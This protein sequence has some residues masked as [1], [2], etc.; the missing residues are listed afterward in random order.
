MEVCYF[1][2]LVPRHDAKP[3]LLSLCLCDET[4]L[5]FPFPFFFSSLCVSICSLIFLL[6]FLLLDVQARRM[7]EQERLD[8][9]IGILRNHTE[10]VCLSFFSFLPTCY[11]T[12]DV[13]FALFFRDFGRH[14]ILI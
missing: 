3:F 4:F 9:A 8:D 1:G 13:S 10:V 5:F 7:P 14:R 11:F 6:F 12:G 2:S